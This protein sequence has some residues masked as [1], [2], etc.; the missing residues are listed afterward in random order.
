MNVLITG[1]AGFVGRAYLRYFQSTNP[2]ARVDV[3]DIKAPN[4][5][6]FMEPGTCIH[7][8]KLGTKRVTYYRDDCRNFFR[9][10]IKKYDLIIHLAAIVGGR[11]TIEG[12]PLSVASDLAI[13]SDFFNWCVRTGQKRVIYF[14]S[15][16]AYPISMQSR[17]YY[18]RLPESAIDLDDVSTPDLTYGWAKLTGEFLA[19]FA[20]KQGVRVHVFRPFSGYGEDQDLDYPFPSFINRVQRG[21]DPFV[22]WG[23]GEQVRDFIHIDDIT[24]AT[25]KAVELDVQGPVNLG[26]GTPTS[27]RGLAEMMFDVSGWY[28]KEMTFLADKPEGVFYRCS[29]NQKMLSFYKPTISLEEGIRRALI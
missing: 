21:D 10:T 28:P 2:H 8:L 26:S 20:E 22:I 25:M 24:A 16:A 1:G 19:Q 15:S 18:Q 5:H 6:Q 13:D 29:D 7:G 17:L 14:S 11:A 4:N 12:D 3:V 27:F 9:D 23:T